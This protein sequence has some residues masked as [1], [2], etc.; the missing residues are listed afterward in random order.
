MRSLRSDN[1]CA[2]WR[3]RGMDL[4]AD[5]YKGMRSAPH[6][7]RSIAEVL[8]E[9]RCS[10]SRPG[11]ALFLLDRVKYGKIQRRTIGAQ[12]TNKG[13]IQMRRQACM[14]TFLLIC[15]TAVGAIPITGHAEETIQ[16]TV[17]GIVVATNID[18][19]PQTIVVKVLLPKK[20]ELIVGA[21]VP[22]D[23]R[24]MRGKQAARLS[25]VKAGEKVEI[26]YLKGSD[27]LIARS[28]HVR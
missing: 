20:E 9:L 6:A 21:R 28:I 7:P 23:T 15:A 14:L 25:E 27:G 13:G 17:R 12:P 26:M 18:I 16:R 24:I 19:D 4:V 8:N 3:H 1:Y 10:S 2:F 11:M 5:F 22:P